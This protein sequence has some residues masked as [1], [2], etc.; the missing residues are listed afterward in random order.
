MSVIT[1]RNTDQPTIGKE[2]GKELGASA[3]DWK[4][5]RRLLLRCGL[6]VGSVGATLFYINSGFAGL[7][8]RADGVVSR[9]HVTVATAFDGMVS[10]V[11][12]RPGDVVAKGQKIAVVKSM[13]IRKTLAELELERARLRDKLA[14]LQAREQVVRETLPLAK[15]SAERAASF[16]QD[17]DHAQTTGLAVR[18]SLQEMTA[19]SLAAAEHAASLEAEQN[20]LRFELASNRAAF[21]SVISAH[22]ELTTRYNDGTLVASVG[23]HIGPTVAHVGDRL[24]LANSPVTDIFTGKPFVL[25]YLPDS[26]LFS[27]SAGEPVVIKSGQKVLLGRV[28]RLLPL[29]ENL[30]SDLQLPNRAL[31]RGRLVR[32]SLPEASELP[33]DQ[34]VRIT[35]CFTDDCGIVRKLFQMTGAMGPGPG[36]EGS[37]K[38]VAAAS[39]SA[40]RF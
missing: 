28:E 15:S 32:I 33:T 34:R 37:T 26:Y 6:V 14:Q 4:R 20:S 16:L 12:V 8:L 23:G 31:E 7:L 35:T 24:S 22:N 21:E 11:F 10:E 27:I 17:L 25:A 3:I 19:A 9:D 5:L 1:I 38:P 29:S 40:G 36:T 39:L 2:L 13:P 30:P 18:K